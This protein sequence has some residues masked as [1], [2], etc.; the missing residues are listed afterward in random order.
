M[1]LRYGRTGSGSAT[2]IESAYAPAG[3]S[4]GAGIQVSAAGVNSSFPHVGVDG[5]GRP[6][7]LWRATDPASGMDI[8]QA[9]SRDAGPGAWAAPT[10]LSTPGDLD[11]TDYGD[12]Q[13]SVSAQGQAVG[14]W[15]R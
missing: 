15:Q 4:F 3:G 6:A 9:S 12:P 5:Q 8:V 13:L 7:A 10:T 14:V 2:H 1:R 11:A